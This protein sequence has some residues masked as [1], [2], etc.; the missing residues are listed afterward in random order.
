M[1]GFREREWQYSY[2]TSTLNRDQVP[3]DILRDFYTPALSRAV[4]YDRMAGYFRSSSLAAAS[5]GYTSFIHHDGRMRL[6]VGADLTEDDINAILAG[7]EARLDAVLLR[8][9]DGYDAWDQPVIDGVALL[10]YMVATEK[11][12]VRVAIRRDANTG[13]VAPWDFIG[14]GYV[15]EKWFVMRDEEGDKLYG[16]GSFNESR[17]AISLNAENID[18]HCA[19]TSDENRQRTEQAEEEFEDLWNNR[20]PHMRVV[21]MPTAVREKLVHFAS[22][23][24][25]F[26]E[27]N[28]EYLTGVSSM[29][30]EDALRIQFLADAPKMP[31]GRFIGI[32]SAAIEPWPHQEVV[33]RRLVETYPYSYL[34]CD[35][36]GLGKTIECALAIRSL[37]LSRRVKRVLIAAPASIANQWQEELLDKAGLSFARTYASPRISHGYLTRATEFDD[38]LY[39]PDLNI[40]S[41]GLLARKERLEGLEIAR[42][43][44]L[45][46]VDEAQY[47]R[48]KN[49]TAGVEGA[50]E[51]GALYRTLFERLR[52][53]SKS[54]WLAT[55]TPM[56]ID[57]VEVYDLLRLTNR[58]AQFRDDPSAVTRYYEVMGKLAASL[59]GNESYIGKTE[60]AFVGRAFQEIQAT[61]PWLWKHLGQTCI[62]GTNDCVLDE[63]VQR[64]PSEWDY[65][66][67]QR[68]LFSAAPLS[69]VMMRHSR[70][71]LKEYRKN[72]ELASNLAERHVE[73]V[74]AIPMTPEEES[75]YSSLES[76][77]SELSRQIAQANP[78]ERQMMHFYLNFLQLRFASSMYAIQQ[79][80]KRRLERVRETLRVLD[81]RDGSEGNLQDI[82]DKIDEESGGSLD[83]DDLNDIDQDALLR[84]RT[85]RDLRWEE[86]ILVAMA[87][88]IDGIHSDPSKILRLLGI[89][90]LRGADL[91][92]H[93]KQTVIFT[94]FYD[95]LVNI[96][97]YLSN[98]M[99]GARVG[100]YSGRRTCYYNTG[101]GVD[102]DVSRDQVKRLFINGDIE[103]LLCTDAAAEGLNLQTADMLINY[104]MGWNPMKI[105]QRIGRIDRIGQKYSDIYVMNLCYLGSVEETVYGRL[106]ERLQSANLVV[107]PQQISLLPVEMEDFIKLHDG[108][109]TEEELARKSAELLQKQKQ[110]TSAMELSPEDQYQMY[111]N[112]TAAV[113]R[114][115][116]S[117]SWDDL[118]EAV[119]NS[120]YV[121]N[122]CQLIDGGDQIAFNGDSGQLHEAMR[123]N[124][125]SRKTPLMTWGS[126]LFEHLCKTANDVL[127]RHRDV[128]RRI[129]AIGP[130]GEPL[131]GLLV[132]TPDGPQLLCEYQQ[133]DNLR[134][135][136]AAPLTDANVLHARDAL[137]SDA[138][139]E[140]RKLD[141]A[142][143]E[144]TN[145]RYA[146]C[147]VNLIRAT[148]IELLKQQLSEGEE[149]AT[150]A[151]H[152]IEERG[153]QQRITLDEEVLIGHENELLFEVKQYGLS[154]EVLVDSVLRKCCIEYA[155]RSLAGARGGKRGYTT[156]KLISRIRRSGNGR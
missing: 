100:I 88:E 109:M 2:K 137:A 33:A 81:R 9:L 14:D 12:N 44:D 64:G 19:W 72:G 139:A 61:D 43:F 37:V 35:E 77:C 45:V 63:L 70:G 31:S 66:S 142:A 62:D 46:I 15:H 21:D 11:L 106:L 34:L 153:R 42:E 130:N 126:V 145:D 125:A 26:R 110:A 49:P 73:P 105:E 86:H 65:E 71:L 149:L 102:V 136:G 89:L 124:T 39:G 94:R 4:A 138:H 103:I 59:S 120:G 18:I 87:E 119:V 108:E 117:A 80:L 74:I 82:L 25:S 156:E 114:Q 22:N 97:Y 152:A 85:K 36:V 96:R 6:I 155:R 121:R 24:T 78:G 27:I 23:R 55:A 91:P 16:S 143:V 133:L 127:D 123:R 54:I 75:F 79:T 154:V 68:P 50:P 111:R 29:A 7:N 151:I 56:Q 140:I 118:V 141:A 99:P 150:K 53:K 58:V 112:M 95:S 101:E 148:T 1:S 28:G 8:E 76:Y 144:E 134:V 107:G 135:G 129:E 47:A 131:C 32:D 60:W 104:D 13:N 122:S 128:I 67:L 93:Q 51:Y 146:E 48:R 113:R 115:R 40:I 20:I 92:G 84:N 98:R 147:H 69:R 3:T 57:M 132:M 52:K 83:E 38:E 10:A 17:T 116:V 90:D 5:Q 30:L 41:T